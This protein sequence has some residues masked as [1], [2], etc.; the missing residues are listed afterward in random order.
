LVAEGAVSS[1]AGGA[2]EG[3][4][5]EEGA[6]VPLTEGEAP[7]ERLGVGEAEGGGVPLAV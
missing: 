7:G 6:G 2:G 1:V 5:L 3:G 4:G